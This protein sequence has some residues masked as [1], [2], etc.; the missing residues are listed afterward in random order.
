MFIARNRALKR[1]AEGLGTA[2]GTLLLSAES[3]RAPLLKNDRLVGI[4][5]ASL[6][7]DL[8][9]RPGAAEW[10]VKNWKF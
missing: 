10:P 9:Q 3:G 4:F 1:R 6:G 2:L 7:K 5:L 8:L